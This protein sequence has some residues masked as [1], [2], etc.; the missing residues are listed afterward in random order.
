MLQGQYHDNHR[1][2]DVSVTLKAKPVRETI[3]HF[4]VSKCSVSKMIS[5]TVSFCIL[6]MADSACGI[7]MGS[8]AALLSTQRGA[9]GG[10]VGFLG[11]HFNICRLTGHRMPQNTRQK[12]WSFT[13]CRIGMPLATRELLTSFCWTTTSHSA[14]GYSIHDSINATRMLPWITKAPD[15]KSIECLK[16][17]EAPVEMEY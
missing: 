4:H 1:R 11:W 13:C 16:S 12:S 9:F 2:S 5:N 17:S 6:V 8:H 14:T 15:F 10:V 7:G 3:A